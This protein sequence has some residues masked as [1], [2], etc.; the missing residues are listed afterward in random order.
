MFRPRFIKCSFALFRSN[1]HA[2]TPTRAVANS[3]AHLIRTIHRQNQNFL[4]AQTRQMFEPVFNKAFAKNRNVR[5]RSNL[6]QRG[7]FESF[8]RTDQQCFHQEAPF[9]PTT[10]RTVWTRIFMSIQ[11]PADSMYCTSSFT[12]PEKSMLL[13]P[14]TCQKHVRPGFTARRR[15]SA[16]E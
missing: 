2:H 1:D 9:P 15:R 6:R 7:N 14:P 3:S 12:W 8:V 13:R 4:R 16:G 11:K 5:E 10:A